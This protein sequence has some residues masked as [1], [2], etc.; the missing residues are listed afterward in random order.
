MDSS[1]TD[2]L[3]RPLFE[4][5][6]P[7]TSGFSQGPAASTLC[8]QHVVAHS[9][10]PVLDAVFCEDPIGEALMPPH[11]DSCCR[12]CGPLL[13]IGLPQ[14]VHFSW[15]SPVAQASG[16]CDSSG[17]TRHVCAYDGKL[18]DRPCSN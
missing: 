11:P 16:Y 13:S 15:G 4:A 10:W 18:W 1:K 9:A 7:G 17:G 2:M 6:S 8:L 5:Q 3:A 14:K 12:Q